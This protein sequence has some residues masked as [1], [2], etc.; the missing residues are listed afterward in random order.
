MRRDSSYIL[1]QL[2]VHRDYMYTTF[3]PL[4]LECPPRS[5]LNSRLCG[6][7]ARDG[8]TSLHRV[9]KSIYEYSSQCPYAVLP[10]S[11]LIHT[12]IFIHIYILLLLLFLLPFI[13]DYGPPP[14]W[15]VMLPQLGEDPTSSYINANW[16]RGFRTKPDAF[17]A[18]QV[19][20]NPSL[21]FYTRSIY[22]FSLISWIMWS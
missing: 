12:Y 17:I 13:F 8:Y 15:R 5:H 1:F 6:A 14:C 9:Q 3:V 19:S 2:L 11:F 7:G 22:P 16:V 20:L 10:S 18:C 21:F 4:H